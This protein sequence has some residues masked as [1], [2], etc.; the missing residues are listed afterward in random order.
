MYHL[1]PLQDIRELFDIIGK[2]EEKIPAKVYT[3]RLLDITMVTHLFMH[4]L[5]IGHSSIQ[6]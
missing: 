2:G 3:G 6:L 5:M 4:T 1:S